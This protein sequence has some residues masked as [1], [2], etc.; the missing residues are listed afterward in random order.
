[1][2]NI[3]NIEVYRYAKSL[4]L[5]MQEYEEMVDKLTQLFEEEITVTLVDVEDEDDDV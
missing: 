1:M 5:N 4:G 3:Y 2:S